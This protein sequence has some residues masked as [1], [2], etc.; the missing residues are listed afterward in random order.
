[1]PV[2][3]SSDICDV[4]KPSWAVFAFVANVRHDFHTQPGEKLK[5][6]TPVL[7]HA[8]KRSLMQHG[9]PPEKSNG[10]TTAGP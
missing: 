3:N 10:S 7:L 5:K 9:K 6:T 2:I 1:M 8:I 4:G